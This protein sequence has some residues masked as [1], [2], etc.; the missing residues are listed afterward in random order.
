VELDI[1]D[2]SGQLTTTLVNK[3]QAAGTYQVQWNGRD[4]RGLKVPY[5]VYFYHLITGSLISTK[6]MMLL[7]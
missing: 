6:K 3:K 2:I 4:N 7:R 1:F 5:G